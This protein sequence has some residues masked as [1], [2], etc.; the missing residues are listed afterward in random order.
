MWLIIFN[1]FDVNQTT[2]KFWGEL[3]IDGIDFW[4]DN[5]HSWYVV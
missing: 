2:D 4:N 5:I 1:T 3:F